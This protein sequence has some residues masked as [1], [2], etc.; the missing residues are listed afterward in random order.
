MIELFLVE[1]EAGGRGKGGGAG[2]AGEAEAVQVGLRV[3][4][5]SGYPVLPRITVVTLPTTLKHRC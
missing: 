1:L 5:R 4:P 2:P 3:L